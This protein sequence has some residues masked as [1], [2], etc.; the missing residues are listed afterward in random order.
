MDQHD[1][2]APSRMFTIGLQDTPVDSMAMGVTCRLVNPSANANWL[3]V[4]VANV[5]TS[6]VNGVR[7]TQATTVFV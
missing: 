4:I 2:K 5:R 7:I 3:S 6:P 1:G